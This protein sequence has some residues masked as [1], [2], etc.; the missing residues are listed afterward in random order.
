MECSNP[1][2][3]DCTF[4]PKIYCR[5]ATGGDDDFYPTIDYEDD[6]YGIPDYGVTYDDSDVDEYSPDPSPDEESDSLAYNLARLAMLMGGPA[7]PPHVPEPQL[8]GLEREKE[9]PE[10][11]ETGGYDCLFL[12]EVPDSLHCLICTLPAKEANQV[13]CCGK[14]FCKS[15]LWKLKRTEHRA[16]P[17]CRNTKW[18]SFP[19][20]KSECEMSRYANC[21]IDPNERD[22]FVQ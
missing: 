13:D 4:H 9:D 11:T 14:V 21:Y 20:K 15:C 10:P 18:K 16:C 5:M 3:I 12:S 19:D 8:P 7:G 6:F 1:P 17:N 22:N 2:E